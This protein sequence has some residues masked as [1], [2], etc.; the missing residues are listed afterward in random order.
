M[1]P[2]QLLW[3]PVPRARCASSYT[4]TAPLGCVKL[5]CKHPVCSCRCLLPEDSA[6]SLLWLVLEA[7]PEKGVHLTRPRV[8]QQQPGAVK[9]FQFPRDDPVQGGFAAG[10]S[11]CCCL[12]V[13]GGSCRPCCCA[14]FYGHHTDSPSPWCF[15]KHHKTLGTRCL[16]M[17][18]RAL[19]HWVLC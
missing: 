1:L 13:G 16:R 9:P 10:F 6:H 18:A 5:L 4:E 11:H 15:P 17:P 8:Q 14:G 19:W 2:Q 12:W 3:V 7:A